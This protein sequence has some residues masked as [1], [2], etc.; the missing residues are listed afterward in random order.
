MGPGASSGTLGSADAVVEAPPVE[1]TSV[2]WVTDFE[3]G[4]GYVVDRVDVTFTF[5]EDFAG[6]LG[7]YLTITGDSPLPQSK[8]DDSDFD[9]SAGTTTTFEASFESLNI[10]AAAVEDIHVLVCDD[11]DS[12]PSGVCTAP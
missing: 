1:I 6:R 8:N 10:P 7:F 4:P 9:V 5:T 12:A 3:N 11:S 2:E